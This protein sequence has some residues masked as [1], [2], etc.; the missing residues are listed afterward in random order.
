[1]DQS[2]II[3]RRG[4]YSAGL[5]HGM[6]SAGRFRCSRLERDCPWVDRHV[7]QGPRVH[8]GIRNAHEG[9]LGIFI[10]EVDVNVWCCSGISRGLLP[11]CCHQQDKTTCSVAKFAFSFFE[12]AIIP[13]RS[14]R[15]HPPRSTICK[16]RGRWLGRGNEVV[17]LRFVPLSSL[18]LWAGSSTSSSFSDSLSSCCR[19]SACWMRLI[20]WVTTGSSCRSS[21]RRV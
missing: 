16:A 14:H 19:A 15:Y 21:A 18:T 11:S 6:G 1:M 9:K 3:S 12:I 8:C 13:R 10:R 5:L 2:F 4:V 17:A 7:G 20:L